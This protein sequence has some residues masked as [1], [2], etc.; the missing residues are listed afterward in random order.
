MDANYVDVG[1][2]GEQDGFPLGVFRRQG[3]GT[4]PGR[5]Q[6]FFSGRGKEI[7]AVRPRRGTAVF[8]SVKR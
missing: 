4:A 1:T 7:P 5:G 2:L 3:P 8:R 6:T